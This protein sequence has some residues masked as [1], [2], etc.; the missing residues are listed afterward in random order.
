MLEKTLESL[1][2]YSHGILEARILEWVAFPFSRGS[3]QPRDQTEVSH[4]IGRL[5]TSWITKEAQENGVGSWSLLQQIFLTQESHQGLLHCRW[6]LSY[7]GSPTDLLT[8]VRFWVCLTLQV[9]KSQFIILC[10]M[11]WECYCTH[12]REKKRLQ[13]FAKLPRQLSL[14]NCPDVKD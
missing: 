4:I 11:G 13:D 8:L 3:L 14:L 10:R 9:L 5:F 1:W 7:Q 6:I 12:Q 2:L